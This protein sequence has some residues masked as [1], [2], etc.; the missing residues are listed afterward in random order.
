MFSQS[1]T[2]FT[3]RC[4]VTDVNNGYTSASVLKF[5]TEFLSIELD[6]ESELLYDWRFTAN[7][8]VLETHNQ[9]F[10]LPTEHL[11]S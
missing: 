1:V 11:R 10:Y 2:A 5:H 4:L 7:Q 3:S 6:L 9:Q 8:F